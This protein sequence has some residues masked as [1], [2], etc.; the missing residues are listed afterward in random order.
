MDWERYTVRSEQHKWIGTNMRYTR[1]S[2][3]ESGAIYGRLGAAWGKTEEA[4][5]GTLGAEG[6]ET[7]AMYGTLSGAGGKTK[8]PV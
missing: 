6:S 5:Y 1:S 3:N 2:I 7:E 8:K 4:I